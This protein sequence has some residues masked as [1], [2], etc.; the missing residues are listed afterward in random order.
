MSIELFKSLLFEQTDF[1][2]GKA[3]LFVNLLPDYDRFQ[4]IKINQTIF[5]LNLQNFFNEIDNYT[6]YLPHLI[7]IKVLN[8]D[9]KPKQLCFKYEIDRFLFRH[10][11]KPEETLPIDEETFFRKT[12]SPTIFQFPKEF[13][14]WKSK[15]IDIYGRIPPRTFICYDS[16]EN[17][18]IEPKDFYNLLLNNV[19]VM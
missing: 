18:F 12:L 5:F 8:Y 19:E 2:H 7:I 11:H 9:R 10:L 4:Y 17:T 15:M 16:K 6:I 13:Q 1:A 14:K 3:K